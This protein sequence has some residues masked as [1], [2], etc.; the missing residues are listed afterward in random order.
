[1]LKNNS[2]D[3][4]IFENQIQVGLLIN[5][6]ECEFLISDNAIFTIFITHMERDFLISDGDN[7]MFTILI[8]NRNIC[9]KDDKNNSKPVEG[10]REHLIMPITPTISLLFREKLS[11]TECCPFIF[12]CDSVEQISTVNDACCHFAQKKNSEFIVA[13]SSY[14]SKISTTK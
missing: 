9:T 3:A 12:R 8:P 4:T 10:S 1:M 7:D 14:L 6:A 2:N 13:P 5:H 11:E